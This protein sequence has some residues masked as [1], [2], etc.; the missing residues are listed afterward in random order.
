MSDTIREIIKIMD[1]ITWILMY[2]L[3]RDRYQAELEVDIKRYEEL[4]S[5]I[6]ELKTLQAKLTNLEGRDNVKEKEEK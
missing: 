6:E 4:S 5:A 2:Y 3:L 1:K